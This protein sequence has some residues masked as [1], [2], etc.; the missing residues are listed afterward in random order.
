MDKNFKNF[1][2]LMVLQCIQLTKEIII[3]D[4]LGLGER[5]LKLDFKKC[6]SFLR[7]N[8]IL[9]LLFPVCTPLK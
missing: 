4:L 3:T 9:F 6:I 2:L 1:R 7:Q 8:D 5:A